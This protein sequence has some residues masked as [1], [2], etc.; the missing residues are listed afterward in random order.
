M[1]SSQRVRA[2]LSFIHVADAG[3][4][5]GGARAQGISSA[6]ASKNVAGLEKALG[7][8]LMNR[9]R[10]GVALTEAGKALRE[11]SEQIMNLLQLAKQEVRDIHNGIAGT[12]SIG[13][14]ASSG[15]AFLPDRI[16][17]YQERYPLVNFQFWE[18]D[19]SM[20]LDLVQHGVAELG[21][22]RLKDNDGRY[23]RLVFPPEPFVA[24]FPERF[25]DNGSGGIELT[26]LVRYPLMVNRR[27]A[28]M[29]YDACRKRNVQPRIICEGNDVRT[30]LAW[31]D[32]GV[33]VAVASRSAQH[34]IKS[35]R[36]VYREILA[37]DLFLQR[38]LFW[39]KQRE[40]SMAAK[41][42]IELVT[43]EETA[44]L[45]RAENG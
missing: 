6:A 3:S 8:R 18:G 7:V 35:E 26:D 42:F 12:L 13:T 30:L 16:R 2:I 41:H 10:K 15:A 40:L 25:A 11:R 45:E 27:N 1:D 23:E 24:A 39:L 14:V 36:L 19:T 28:S 38:S 22:A 5:A 34:L 17:L 29:F 9:D 43:V 44:Q 37:S 4:F 32:S 20:V 31:A 21:I 33:G